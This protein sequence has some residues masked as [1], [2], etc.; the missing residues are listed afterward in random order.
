MQN[1]YPILYQY[2]DNAP[3]KSTD[4][5]EQVSQAEYEAVMSY[6]ANHPNEG[7]TTC[8]LTRYFIQNVG[9]SYDNYQLKFMNGASVHHTQ[10]VTGGNQMDYLEFNGTHISDYN[11][12]YGPRALCVELMF[13]IPRFPAISACR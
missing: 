13:V 11:A 8:N 3:E 4:R 5:N 12:H 10:E 6:L 7:G 1:Q 9:S 2:F